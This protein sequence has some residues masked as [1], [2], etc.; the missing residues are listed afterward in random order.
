MAVE[1]IANIK[2]VASLGQESHVFKRY[3]E[4]VLKA[5][6]AC[7]QKVRYRGL[8]FALGQNT[9]LFGYALA[10]S[11]GGY[12]VANE[13]LEYKNVIKLDIRQNLLFII[14]NINVCIFRI[15]EA[16]IFGA[17]M[18][19]QALSYAPNVN[20]AVLSAARLLRL[21]DRV[22]QYVAPTKEPVSKALVNIYKAL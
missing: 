4:E 16:L 22:P 18:L 12:M 1:A 19:A 7:K 11:Y 9:P 21:L 6:T 17:W 3:S 14:G 5:E 10:F 13:G 2:T 8:V 20:V 15:S